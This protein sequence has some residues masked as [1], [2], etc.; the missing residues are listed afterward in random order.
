MGQRL[1]QFIVQQALS[2]LV[3]VLYETITAAQRL[4]FKRPPEAYHSKPTDPR[5]ATLDIK[6]G[7]WGRLQA[8]V[9]RNAGGQDPVE[10]RL[11]LHF[12]TMSGLLPRPV[13]FKRNT[14]D[15]V[16]TTSRPFSTSR[17]TTMNTVQPS[18][19]RLP[20]TIEI[21]SL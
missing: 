8:V 7:C 5:K 10:L 17:S 6:R 18:N 3:S 13:K 15:R 20:F 2:S 4:G 1:P 19:S 11:L 12:Y 16:S 21:S 14:A 9:S